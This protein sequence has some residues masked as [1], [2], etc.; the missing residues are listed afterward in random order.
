MNELES[1]ANSPLRRR[2]F[3][4]R[5]GAAGLGVAA[6]SL[7]SGCGGGALS[8]TGLSGGG[9]ATGTPFPVQSLPGGN[10]NLK[11]LNFAL[12]LE[13]LE[14]DLYR[15]ALNRASGLALT[16]PLSSTP[17]SYALKV[18]S[19]SVNNPNAFL[20]LTQFAYSEAAHRDFL[21]TVLK[22]LGSPAVSANAKGYAFP[23][24]DP[25]A[26]LSA[27]IT[28]LLPLEETGVRAYLGAVPYITD[29]QVIGPT[30]GGIFSTE[31]R[32]SA[33]FNDL[34]GHDPGPTPGQVPG[35][36]AVDPN[37]PVTV[38]ANTFE[39]YLAPNTVLSIAS[40]FIVH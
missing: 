38:A 11:V 39:R 30:A 27:I 13:F 28:N 18:G 34:I 23:G 25:G 7:L 24:G 3:L 33:V 19:G 16:T 2:A 9:G 15:Q 26:T 32:H 35:D 29:Y 31:A 36:L 21:I 40:Q 6:A 10:N 4:A 8:G 5:M 17:S 22:S 14:A 20:Y 37:P 12:T 1:I